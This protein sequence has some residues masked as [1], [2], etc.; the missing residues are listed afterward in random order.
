[1]QGDA[2]SAEP[3]K[4]K[5]VFNTEHTESTEGTAC[6]TDFSD[7]KVTEEIASDACGVAK[8]RVC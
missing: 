3:E 2:R 1:M 6:Y 5:G 8:T 4:G 7:A